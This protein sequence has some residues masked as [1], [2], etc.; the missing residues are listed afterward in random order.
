MS[1]T[2]YC[3][4]KCDVINILIYYAEKTTAKEMIKQRTGNQLTTLHIE[5]GPGSLSNSMKFE[6]GQDNAV[7]IKGNDTQLAG[8]LRQPIKEV[9][10]SFPTFNYFQELFKFN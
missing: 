5:F 6:Y 7:D 3:Q 8:K 10:K 9:A 2:R 4:K 1:L